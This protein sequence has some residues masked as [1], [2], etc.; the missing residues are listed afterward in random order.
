MMP[1]SAKVYI[2]PRRA[3]QYRHLS[4]AASV[5]SDP[6]SYIL[7]FLRDILTPASLIASNRNVVRRYRLR[8]T[9][10]YDF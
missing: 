1:S 4:K 2:A 3:K 8:A 7:A 6:T 5:A 9:Y 10:G